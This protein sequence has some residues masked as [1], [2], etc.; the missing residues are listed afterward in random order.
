MAV[1]T[2]RST[3]IDV[4]WFYRVDGLWK[5]RRHQQHG[6]ELDLLKKEFLQ[7]VSFRYWSQ[8]GDGWG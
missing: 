1:E 5:S 2:L 4:S 8:E 6:W 3:A 7:E